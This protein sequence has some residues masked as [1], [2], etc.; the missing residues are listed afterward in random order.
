M[1]NK[2]AILTMAWNEND[3]KGGIIMWSDIA[4]R[5]DNGLCSSMNHYFLQSV[6]CRQLWLVVVTAFITF[7][8][9]WTMTSRRFI[10]A[11]NSRDPDPILLFPNL[12]RDSN[13]RVLLISWHS[14]SF[15]T[16][17]TIQNLP[18]AF[19]GKLKKVRICQCE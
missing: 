12:S 4:T 15:Q 14:E 3:S 5:A 16:H 2:S 11:R 6:L 1:V 19:W 17:G 18:R 13:S 10:V 9:Y 8:L 7:N